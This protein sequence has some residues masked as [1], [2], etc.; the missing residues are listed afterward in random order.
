MRKSGRWDGIHVEDLFDDLPADPRQR[1]KI[2]WERRREAREQEREKRRQWREDLWNGRSNSSQKNSS[3]TIITILLCMILAVLLFGRE[4]VLGSLK[5]Y[6][7]GAAIAGVLALIY[8]ALNSVVRVIEGIIEAFDDVW[9]SIIESRFPG[10]TER[11]TTG[12]FQ[13]LTACLIVVGLAVGLW[14]ARLMINPDAPIPDRPVPTTHKTDCRLQVG[15]T[16]CEQVP[17]TPWIPYDQLPVTR[18]N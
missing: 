3:Q 6:A 11:V 4:A 9:Y 18:L 17:G 13:R 8:L 2:K 14:A 15:S 16:R 12:R 10:I 1:A 5:G 7:I